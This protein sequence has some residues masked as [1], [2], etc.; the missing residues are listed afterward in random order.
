MNLHPSTW[1]D[2]NW[3]VIEVVLEP[4]WENEFQD[5]WQQH[6]EFKPVWTPKEVFHLYRHKSLLNKV[7]SFCFIWYNYC[8]WKS[9][10]SCSVYLSYSLKH[11]IISSYC[12]TSSTL[13]LHKRNK[14]KIID[15]PYVSHSFQLFKFFALIVFVFEIGKMINRFIIIVYN[16]FYIGSFKLTIHYDKS[17]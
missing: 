4:T 11:F 10:V 14:R 2:D 16:K 6:A 1:H 9:L 15:L 5:L 7:D 12:L 3:I 8:V 17:N 13:N